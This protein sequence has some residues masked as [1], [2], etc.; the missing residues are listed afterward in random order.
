VAGVIEIRT[1]RAQPGRRDELTEVLEAR[2]FPLHKDIGIRVLGIFPPADE[3]DTL[4]W[5]RAFPDA[6]SK[7]SMT[8]ALYG[9]P[10][11]TGEIAGLVPPLIA[12]HTVV[13]IDDAPGLWSRWP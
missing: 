4:V 11:W 1:Y 2:V 6:A 13:T 7:D 8:K 3:A 5:L 9:G 10:A 12:E